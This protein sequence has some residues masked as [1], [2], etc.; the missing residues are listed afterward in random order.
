MKKNELIILTFSILFLVSIV[1]II[2]LG[3]ADT[4]PT[5]WTTDAVVKCQEAVKKKLYGAKLSFDNAFKHKGTKEIVKGKRF[6]VAGKV[7]IG[8]LQKNYGCFVVYKNNAY[9]VEVIL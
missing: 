1:G 2:A 8:K 5:V 4:K 3:S 6:Q 7:S 9:E